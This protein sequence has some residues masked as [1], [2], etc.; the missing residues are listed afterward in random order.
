MPNPHHRWGLLLWTLLS[1]NPTPAP[2]PAP[3][4]PAPAPAPAPAPEPEPEPPPRQGD[5][6]LEG[7]VD[8]GANYLLPDKKARLGSHTFMI[9]GTDGPEHILAAH[10]SGTPP[11]NYQFVLRVRLSEAERA[12]YDRLRA[13]STTLPAFT[14]IWYDDGGSGA[15]QSRT[16]FCLHDLS[17]MFDGSDPRFDSQFPI[18]ASLLKDGDHERELKI[19]QSH[20]PGGHLTLSRS[21][22]SVAV[23]RYLP[24]YLDQ[25]D[26]RAAI[27]A[28]PAGMRARMSHAPIAHTEPPEEAAAHQSYLRGIGAEGSGGTCPRNYRLPGAE[29]P[30]TVHTFLLLAEQDSGEVLAVHLYDAA[31]H[32][33]Q[34]ALRIR[35]DAP[36]LE[37]FRAARAA[38]GVP[39]LV[40]EQAF[41]M[42]SLRALLEAGELS[43]SGR[44][45][46]GGGLGPLEVGAA[47]GRVEVGGADVTVLVNRELGSLM[48]PVAVYADVVR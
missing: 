36:E 28:D 21:D 35:L 8:C 39:L 11:H 9:L 45:H 30:E 37:V 1:C 2:T 31:P 12:F 14:T 33:F 7:A 41:C 20:Y 3:A 10:R 16:F 23:Y 47:V 13:E 27:A 25:G 22:V 19:R 34:S 43:L 26:L 5:R 40:T 24:A 29:V 32:N 18:G 4:P 46:G 48:D 6:K 38:G 42:A 44:V 15:Q 17:E